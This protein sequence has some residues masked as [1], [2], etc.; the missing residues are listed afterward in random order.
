MCLP[1]PFQHVPFSTSSPHKVWLQRQLPSAASTTVVLPNPGKRNRGRNRKREKQRESET[2]RNSKRERNRE[3]EKQ[4]D[5]GFQD[6]PNVVGD[7]K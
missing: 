3:R 2:E 4:R 6:Q 1:V 5:T 7:A